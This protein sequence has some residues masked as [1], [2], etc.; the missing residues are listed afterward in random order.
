MLAE[1]G[2]DE[3]PDKIP[4]PSSGR[5]FRGALRQAIF[6][7]DG[8]R[9]TRC[10]KTP[11]DGITLEVDHVVE[12]E[13]G[14]KTEYG[15]GQTICS[16]CN[17]GKHSLKAVDAGEYITQA[18]F[19]RRVGAHRDTIA[20][21][22]SNGALDY[23]E[24]TGKINFSTQAVRWMRRR[25]GGDDDPKMKKLAQRA[26]E[27]QMNK[28]IYQSDSAKEKL[29]Q[30]KLKTLEMK[31]EL[32]PMGLITYWFSFAD[33]LIQRIH[34]RPNEI[35]PEIEALI[36]GHESDKALLKIKR[37]LEAVIVAAKKELYD[38]IES[39]GYDN[40]K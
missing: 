14:G 39:E 37:E 27:A 32:G 36:L 26:L 34:R 16:D 2:D 21:A 35:W 18:E 1:D 8:F 33:N 15:N 7:R 5:Y 13:D 23:D 31:R 29:E 20:D 10:G 11:A 28:D 17:K 25:D 9:C 19:A 38:S 40:I 30:D 6:K 24:T 3:V 12:Y 22:I 4:R